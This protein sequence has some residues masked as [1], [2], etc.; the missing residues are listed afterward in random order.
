M[1]N[2]S[3]VLEV[4][5]DLVV[6]TAFV[7]SLFLLFS[8]HNAPGGGFIAGLVAAIAVVLRFIAG[9]RQWVQ[10]VLPARPEVL[11]GVGLA[12]A[13]GTGVLGWV[14]GGSFL[15]STKWEMDL[16]IL[17]LVKATS[18][19]PFDIGVFI[20]VVGLATAMLSALGEGEDPE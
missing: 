15:E 2:R 16:P 3:F 9:G 14:W 11:L 12:I 7:F 8:G 6:R 10:D 1:I 13:L 5:I 17:G 19:L 4:L 20:V 18:A